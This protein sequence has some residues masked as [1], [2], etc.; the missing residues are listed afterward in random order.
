MAD[1]LLQ[2]RRVARLRGEND[3]FELD[4]GGSIAPLDIAYETY[5]RLNARR[6]NAIL[7]CH[8]LT[9]S[10]HAAG[11][12]GG[13][14]AARS[15]GWW[16]ALI[17]P[18]RAF[19]TDRYF[20]VCSN[21]LGGCY[22]STGPDS[23]DPATGA[24]Y[25]GSFPDITVRDIVRA[26]RLLLLRLGIERVFA[27]AGG[28]MGGMQALEWAATYPESVD[29]ILPIAT[30][31]AHSP[32]SIAFNAIA[33]EAISLGERCGD[34]EA[35]LRLARKAAMI[36][37]RSPDGFLE[38]FGRKRDASSD[39][40]PSDD[41]PSDGAPSDGVADGPCGLGFAVERYLEHHG[42]RLVQR[43]G[44][45]SY[46]VLTK[47]M[48]LHD[49]GRGRGTAADVLGRIEQPALVCGITSDVLYPESEQRV[50]AAGLANA[51]YATID[52]PHGHDAFLIEFGQLDRIVRRFLAEHDILR[53]HHSTYLHEVSA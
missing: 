16:D 53:S 13:D 36:S 24:A 46:D 34:V 28:S 5:G 7:I 38:R 43:F 10:A 11:P 8:A 14:G 26:Q 23:M 18:A 39:D 25:G 3:P 19:D 52:S 2:T 40:A 50:L 32:W 45:A 22:G 1:T 37:Y 17:G 51:T 20:V 41:A 49:I 48:D 29:T 21:V 6:D 4:L 44:A 47:A 35:G 15:S 33:R 30:S 31:A 27:V 12:Q 9:G 42:R